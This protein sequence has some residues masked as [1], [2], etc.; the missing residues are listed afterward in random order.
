M[1]APYFKDL[2]YYFFEFIGSCVN[3]V[4]AFVGWYP[5]L[6]LG[7]RFLYKLEERRFSNETAQ[8][9]ERRANLHNEAE[10]KI[11]KARKNL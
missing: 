5:R 7:I 10:V 6:E 8:Q 1:I 4:G 2:V 3:F 11:G 9:Q